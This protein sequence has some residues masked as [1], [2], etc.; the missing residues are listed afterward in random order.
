MPGSD[1][2]K[3]CSSVFDF[4]CVISTC[5]FQKRQERDLLD[6]KKEKEETLLL[7]MV[8]LNLTVFL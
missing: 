4:C 6:Q 7:E 1:K 2:D 5:Q 8:S 3:N